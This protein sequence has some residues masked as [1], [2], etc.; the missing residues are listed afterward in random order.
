MIIPKEKH[1]LIRITKIILNL[2]DDHQVTQ[3]DVDRLIETIQNHLSDGMSPKNIRD[4]YN[5]VYSDFGMFLKTSLHIKLLPIKS[6]VNLYFTKTGKKITDEKSI[7]KSKCKFTFDPYSMKLDGY[8]RLLTYGIY[9]PVNNP[10][11]MVRDH[12]VSREFGYL[13]RIDPEIISHPANCRY[14]S[15]IENIIKG[16]GC[17][18]TVDTLINR[19][20]HW[21]NAEHLPTPTNTFD[22]PPMSE[23]TKAL[24]S[25]SV[26]RYAKN[27]PFINITNGL[28][29][30]HWPVDSPIPAGYR[31]GLTRTK[32]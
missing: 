11:G 5:I 15:N 24:L 28:N 18:I 20:E 23:S 1:A 12:M 9:H 14:I 6:A 21:D 13:N 17:C 3:T 30:K 2:P 31:R 4:H 22:R 7:Y 16:S 8:D 10:T 19:I 27:H 26:A 32:K 29:N 25:A